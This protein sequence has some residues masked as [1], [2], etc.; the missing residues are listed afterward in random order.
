VRVGYGASDVAGG[1][2]RLL[3]RK[4]DVLLLE[5]GGDLTS[6]VSDLNTVLK[7][8][9]RGGSAMGAH[10]RER[11]EERFGNEHFFGAPTRDNL[12]TCTSMGWDMTS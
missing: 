8:I 11:R 4:R 2:D 12:A 1:S 5:V 10:E 6:R 9:A 3:P 7:N